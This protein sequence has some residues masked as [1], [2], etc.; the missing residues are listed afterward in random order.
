MGRYF[1]KDTPLEDLERIMMQGP[2]AIRIDDDIPNS[3]EQIQN[4]AS[5]E[6]PKTSKNKWPTI[7]EMEMNRLGGIE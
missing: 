2:N 5:A 6:Q 4:L 3:N 1:F 7:G